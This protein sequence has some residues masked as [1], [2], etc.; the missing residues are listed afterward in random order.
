[1]KRKLYLFPVLFI[2]LALALSG[3]GGTRKYRPSRPYKPK[4]EVHE[5]A[6]LARKYFQV[7]KE[8][9]L[10]FKFHDSIRHLQ[11]AIAYEN[12]DTNKA[13][14]YLYIGA[15]YFYLKNFRQARYSFSQAK[16]HNH[17]LRPPRSEFPLE[18][19]RLYNSTP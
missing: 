8:D 7:G 18:I 19:I 15:N 10:N 3:C 6:A 16:K 11:Q 1:M 4:T 5:K 17:A 14:C 13:N 12:S 9:Y 2:I